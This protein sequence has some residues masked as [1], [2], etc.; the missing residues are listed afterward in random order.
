MISLQNPELLAFEC[1][2]R[3]DER[4]P[5]GPTPKNN[6]VKAEL[7][8]WYVEAKVGRFVAPVDS[9][10]PAEQNVGPTWRPLCPNTIT[11]HTSA[12]AS[13]V[14]LRRRHE[15]DEHPGAVAL[16]ANNPANVNNGRSEAKSKVGTSGWRQY[17][18]CHDHR[19][20]QQAAPKHA[21][22]LRVQPRSRSYAEEARC[23]NI[24]SP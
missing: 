23:A 21:D 5:T 2:P 24:C 9:R 15:I 8:S 18:R 13:E 4:A 14:R 11:A 1:V 22:L 17:R 3:D 12:D 19:G 16:P 10:H 6:A 7:H 20:R